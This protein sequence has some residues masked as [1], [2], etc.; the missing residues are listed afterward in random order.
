MALKIPLTVR[1]ELLTLKRK[2]PLAT[3]VYFVNIKES[4]WVLTHPG[5]FFSD[6]VSALHRMSISGVFLIGGVSRE[7]P[8]GVLEIVYGTVN[9]HSRLRELYCECESSSSNGAC[10]CKLQEL[11]SSYCSV[12]E[13]YFMELSPEDCGKYAVMNCHWRDGFTVEL[14]PKG[15]LRERL[16]RLTVGNDYI[17]PEFVEQIIQNG[18]LDEH[19]TLMISVLRKSEYMDLVELRD[20]ICEFGEEWVSQR[21]G[22]GVC[23]VLELP[24]ELFVGYGLQE[25]DELSFGISGVSLEGAHHA[26]ESVR[27]KIE[28]EM[29]MD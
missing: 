11:I 25:I 13:N 12:P 23:C 20:Y 24:R 26:L 29:E 18:Y 2:G 10:R 1:K 4:P 17:R 19:D 3:L 5:A 15:T 9:L 28:N 6:S 14:V 8:V 22:W 16:L 7:P 21:L 27:V